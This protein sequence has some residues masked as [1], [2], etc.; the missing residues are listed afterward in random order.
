MLRQVSIISVL[1]CAILIAA[2]GCSRDYAAES[3]QVPHRQ[4]AGEYPIKVVCTTGPVADMLQNIGGDHLQVT[5]MMGPGVDPH[6]Y[7]AVPA[8]IERLSG[9]D[10]IFYNGLHLEGR[11]ADLFEQLAQ[12]K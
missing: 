3:A 4:F 7:K 12:R 1:L 2:T 9:A 5:G 8:D 10:A 11:M 6:L